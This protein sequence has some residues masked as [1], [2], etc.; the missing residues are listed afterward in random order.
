[1]R[2]GARLLAVAHADLL[3]GLHHLGAVVR[4]VAELLE[5]LQ[6]GR[7]AVQRAEYAQPLQLRDHRTQSGGLDSG[8]SVV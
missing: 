8:A 3:A 1:M 7:A 5:R 6:S 4:F 2:L